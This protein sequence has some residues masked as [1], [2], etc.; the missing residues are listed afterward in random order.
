MN[1]WIQLAICI[2]VFIVGMGYFE[3]AVKACA[4]AP[5][6]MNVLIAMGALA[7][8]VYSLTSTINLNMDYIL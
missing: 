3:S 5:P 7:A 4:G 1:P 6:N 8:F 2:P